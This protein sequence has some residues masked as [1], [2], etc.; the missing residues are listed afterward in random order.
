MIQRKTGEEVVRAYEEYARTP[1]GRLR[2]DLV[3]RYYDHFLSSRPVDWIFDVGGGSGLLLQRL[4]EARTTQR[5]VLIDDDE[6]ML[7]AAESRLRTLAGGNQAECIRGSYRDLAL[8]LAARVRPGERALVAFNHVIEYVED[9]EAALVTLAGCLP[10]GSYLGIMYLN[11][12]HEA[13][14][15]LWH[16]DSIPG[17]LAQLATGEFDAVTFGFARAMLTD[18]LEAALEGHRLLPLEEYGIRCVSE[19]KSK[20]FVKARYA[21]LLEAEFTAGAHKDFLGLARYRLKFHVRPGPS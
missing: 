6:A 14:R 7:R 12:S 18:R 16:R 8:L 5:S 19:F 1:H 2:H 13:L 9:Q 3:Y 4:L 21:E 17:M 15:R 11:N 20:E 10:E